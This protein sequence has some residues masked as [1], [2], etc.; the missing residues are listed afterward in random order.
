MWCKSLEIHSMGLDTNGSAELCLLQ[1]VAETLGTENERASQGII[2][3]A[4]TIPVIF[5]CAA[6]QPKSITNKFALLEL[7]FMKTKC[8]KEHWFIN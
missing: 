3:L 7:Y 5:Q 6:L 8:V 4:H 1:K 2:S